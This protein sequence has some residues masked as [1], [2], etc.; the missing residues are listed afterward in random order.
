MN[1]TLLFCIVNLLSQ[2]LCSILVYLLRAHDLR[3]PHN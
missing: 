2:L 1:L 3:R